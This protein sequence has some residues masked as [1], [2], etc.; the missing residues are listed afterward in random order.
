MLQEVT[1]LLLEHRHTLA[2]TRR[3]ELGE[4]AEVPRVI[5]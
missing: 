3:L 1:R 4:P 2:G 5:C